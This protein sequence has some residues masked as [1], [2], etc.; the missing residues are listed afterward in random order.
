M[1]SEG[2]AIIHVLCKF[3]IYSISKLRMAGIVLEISNSAYAKFQFH[4]S[5]Q[6]VIL[7]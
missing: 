6:I 5:T 4:A 2:N 7:L 1:R 3:E